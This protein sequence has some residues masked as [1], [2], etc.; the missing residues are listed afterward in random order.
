ML[1][2]KEVH[3]IQQEYQLENIKSINLE[4]LCWTLIETALILPA[5]CHSRIFYRYTCNKFRTRN[6]ELIKLKLIIKY[7]KRFSGSNSYY[8]KAKIINLNKNFNLINSPSKNMHT[9]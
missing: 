5:L 4:T 1:P 2:I 6:N 8:N 7:N 9:K 3:K